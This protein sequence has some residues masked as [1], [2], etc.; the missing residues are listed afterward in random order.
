MTTFLADLRYAARVLWRNRGVAV[1]FITLALAIGA[2]TAIFTVFDALLRALPFPTPTAGPGRPRLS[3]RHRRRGGVPKFLH[4]REEAAPSSALRGLRLARV[5]IQSR[6]RGTPDRLTGS[7]VSSDF[8][9]DAGRAPTVGR[10]FAPHEDLPGG[11]KV[12]VLS[13]G[14]WARRFGARADIVGPGVRLNDEP[15]TVIGVMPEGF[16]FPTRADLW[17]LFQFDPASH[18]RANYFEVSHACAPA[19]TTDRARAAMVS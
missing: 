3:G 14:L 12:V 2:T 5:G 19:S 13:H 9:A 16:R 6:G 10:D 17:T 4:W 18:D 11:P 15:Y 1:A 7:R 8:F